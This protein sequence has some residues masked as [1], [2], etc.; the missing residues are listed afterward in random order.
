MLVQMKKEKAQEIIM[1]LDLFDGKITLSELLDT[2]IPIIHQLRD[3]KIALNAQK[4]QEQYAAAGKEQIK[5][6][7]TSTEEIAERIKNKG[8]K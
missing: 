5:T 1:L 7:L 4:Q 2:D 6:T 8:N 3:A